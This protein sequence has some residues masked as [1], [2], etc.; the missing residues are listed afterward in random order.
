MTAR[1]FITGLAGTTLTPAER[2]FLREADP[3]GLIVFTRNIDTPA[4]VSCLTAAFREAVGR[5]A[6]VLVDQE[7]G[8]VQRLGPPHWPAYP[9]GATYGRIYQRDAAMGLKAAHLGARLIAADLRAVGIDV[10]CLPIADVPVPGA[11]SIIGE[12]AYGDTADQVA[13]LARAVADGLLAEGVLPV[14][15]HIPGHG[16]A[17][18]DS[19]GDLPVVETDRATLMSTDFAAFRPLFDL[20]LGMTAHVV[21]TAIDPLA[22]ATTSVTLVRD[23]IRNWL[24]FRGLL[25]SDDISMGALSGS[26]GERSRAA[27]AAGCDVVLHCN[28]K[29]DEMQA[30][31]AAVPA[32]GGASSARADAALGC[33]AAPEQHDI[34]ALRAEWAALM[35]A[36]AQAADARSAIA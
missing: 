6:P 36:P 30:V 29:L 24:G 32:L 19:H 22:P 10:D 15:K 18:V 1:A 34:P 12:R 25:M 20:P 31:A 35:N 16:R 28:G 23:V 26:L 9:A 17:T 27:I 33:R 4:Q 7:G 5:D 13:A 14:L 8:R 11:H 2:S 21:Y 3:W